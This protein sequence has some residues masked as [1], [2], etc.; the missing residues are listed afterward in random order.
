MPPAII[1]AGPPIAGRRVAESA[2]GGGM[3]PG[4]ISLHWSP[5]T[6]APSFGSKRTMSVISFCIPPARS[7]GSQT[8]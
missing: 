8:L 1:P 5:I 7:Q 4:K 6:G 3:S 2:L